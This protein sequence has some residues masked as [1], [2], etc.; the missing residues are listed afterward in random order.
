M[1]IIEQFNPRTQC[2]NKLFVIDEDDF[3]PNSTIK[4]NKYNGPYRCRK[5]NVVTFLGMPR[6]LNG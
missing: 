1:L 5:N 2:W 6:K 4:V 3:D